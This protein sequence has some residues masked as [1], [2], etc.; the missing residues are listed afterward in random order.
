M[1]VYFHTHPA[2]TTLL[3]Y[4]AMVSGKANIFIY[5]SCGKQGSQQQS[6]DSTSSTKH[7]ARY[8]QRDSSSPARRWK[9]GLCLNTIWRQFYR[10]Q[11][12]RHLSFCFS[13]TSGRRQA[14]P[15]RHSHTVLVW[16]GGEDP[17]THQAGSHSPAT[18]VKRPFCEGCRAGSPCPSS[19]APRSPSL[20][21]GGGDGL[22]LGPGRLWVPPC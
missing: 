19:A 14:P 18:S 16:K 1:D 12:G 9:G 20:R 10:L 3:H 13:P 8:V 22:C 21:K 15:G 2:L 6:T 7:I 5:K 11:L 4:Y 17:V